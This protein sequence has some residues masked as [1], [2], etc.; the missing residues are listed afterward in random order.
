MLPCDDMYLRSAATQRPNYPV[1]R[2]D[3][4]PAI[5]EKEFVTLLEREI[6]YHLKTEKAKHDLSLRYDWTNY[7]AFDAI[8]SGR[9]GAV[10]HKNVSSFMRLNGYYATESEQIAIIRRLDVDADQKITFEEF[11]EAFKP[12]SFARTQ[13]DNRSPQRNSGNDDDY[14]KSRGS[15]LRSSQYG[16]PPVEEEKRREVPSSRGGGGLDRSADPLTTSQLGSS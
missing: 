10:N 1:G 16:K 13:E 6:A 8:D 9:E 4:L 12:A 3:R 5:V 11:C 15:P 14:N 7:G 2:Y